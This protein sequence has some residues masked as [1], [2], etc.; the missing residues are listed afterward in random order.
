VLVVSTDPAHSLGD[1]L[2]CSLTARPKT[3]AV[4]RGSLQACELDA[5][6]ALTRWLATRRPALATILDR[7]TWLTRADVEA[8]LD[9]ALPG[10]DEL[11]GLVEIERLSAARPYD[12]VIIDTAPTGHT[13]RLLATPSTF[14]GL[15]RALDLMQEKHRVVAAALTHAPRSDASDA[16]IAEMAEDGKRL[17]SLLRDGPRTRMCW[18]TLPEP[19]AVAES[20]RAIASLETDGIRVSEILLNRLTPPPPSPCALCDNRRRAESEALRA[21]P[22]S[23]AGAA[24]KV[25]IV[26]AQETPAR[27]IAALRALAR[28]VVPLMGWNLAPPANAAPRAR[29]TTRRGHRVIASVVGRPSTRLLIVGGKGGVGKTT[30]AAALAL[31]AARQ[32]P[33]RHILLLST[34]PAHSL[35]DVFDEPIGNMERRVREGPVNLVARELDAAAGWRERTERYRESVS[36]M[37]DAFDAGGHAHLAMDR[38]IL[39]E[40]F[41]LAPPGMDEITGM[42][43]IVDAVFPEGGLPRTDL[44]IM[45]TAP[46][47]HAL[48]LLA[49]PGQAHAWVRQFM[50][51]LL[52]FEGAAG[53]GELASELLALSRGLDRL[54][55][56]LATPRECGFVV[57]TRPERLAIVETVRLV[58]WLR[59]H[60]ISRRAL[61]VN[62]CTPPGCRRCKR[63]AAR[64]RRETTKIAAEPEWRRSAIVETD[65]VTPPPRGVRQ[66]EAWSGTWRRRRDAAHRS[67]RL[68]LRR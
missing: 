19:L 24:R 60:H 68:R 48:R 18:V 66:L 37:V 61:I 50:K 62:A 28:T 25:S 2:A 47:G 55:R 67:A 56:L 17:A 14:I 1:V 54:E 44:A 23:L 38:A 59:A 12:Q 45:D 8:F 21:L 10:V 26:P 3:L 65:A 27:G 5:D 22:A 34:D 53:F 42:L 43:A 39:E 57:V 30:C 13:L 64:E 31:A 20:T 52:E 9:L 40:L 4:A 51:V 46:T 6:S 33:A 41:S 11:L 63:A 15:A 35:G 7:G 49:V 58:E 36:R 16:L 29:A 32:D